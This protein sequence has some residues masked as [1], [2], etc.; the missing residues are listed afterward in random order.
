MA[1]AFY[2]NDG[3]ELRYPFNV[4]SIEQQSLSDAENIELAGLIEKCNEVL[5]ESN[6][7]LASPEV[8]DPTS[9][10]NAVWQRIWIN[11][12]KEPEK[13]LYNVV[14]LFVF[15]F[16]SDVGVLK[17][18][19]NFEAVYK[20]LKNEKPSDA[21][22]HYPKLCRAKIMSLFPEG[23]DGTTIINGTIFVNEEGEPNLAQARLFGEIIVHFKNYE[24]RHGS[25]RYIKRDFK[26]RLY[27][28]FLRQSA[29]VRALGQYFTPR[30]V[31]KAIVMMSGAENLRSGSRVCDPFCGVGGFLLELIEEYDHI[32]QEFV[33]K[34]GALSP[35]ITLVGYDKGSDE[36]EDERTIILA[37][38]NMLIYFSD[39]L[40]KHHSKKDLE[41]FATGALNA[42]FRLLR[43]NL[44]T[45]EKIDDL[46]Y[47][48]IMTNPPYVT[49]G[50]SSIRRALI[51]EGHEERYPV[52][53]HGTEALAMQWVIRNL[54]TRG[55]AFVIVPDGLVN[56]PNLLKH[57]KD[58]CVVRGIVSLPSRTFYAT[59][60]RTY[61]LVLRKK[62]DKSVR[63]TEPTFAYVISEI[64]ET[65]DA[66]RMDLE[67]NDL[68][69]MV[70]MFK[71]F[72]AVPNAFR[73]QS[74]R[75][76]VFDFESFDH[77]PNWMI[78]RE[79]TKDERIGLKL[80]ESE[81]TLSQTNYASRLQG[82]TS[83]LG[84]FDKK[85]ILLNPIEES[86]TLNLG[87]TSLFEFVKLK[88][89]WKKSQYLE[90]DTGNAAD[91]PVYSAA[92]QPVAHVQQV[93]DK[94]ID[95]SPSTRLL[96]FGSNG[97]G[98]AGRNFVTHDCPF[99]VSNDRT[100]L[101]MLCC[102]ILPEF[103]RY[104]LQPMK[105][106]WGFGFTF[107]AT[108]NNLKEVA[109]DVPVAMDGSFD[110]ARQRSV[111]NEF[112]RLSA[113]RQEIEDSWQDLVSARVVFD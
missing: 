37:K 62:P 42:V 15:K 98:S 83:L 94:L 39:L 68:L 72:A 46:P 53:G 19:Y 40:A 45:F 86:R 11:T 7:R 81:K 71:Q 87:D 14:E 92:A 104:A 73:P 107:K 38:A 59:P 4:L 47:D 24:R 51:A 50:S 111:G 106:D 101:K 93:N 89:G 108:P 88:T 90:L 102:D 13:C 8:L 56:Q 110:V 99:Y 6:N 52:S 23:A 58:E 32:R 21:L 105:A 109:F 75:C 78:D 28:S 97:D 2:P 70:A 103:V 31:V 22:M 34:N 55:D 66:R 54:K 63:Q 26:T 74:P 1:N 100:V 67:Q 77:F 43:S 49:S 85:S 112:D 17:G 60:K 113:L 61:I 95:C 91:I 64:G 82:L 76:K 20:V 25:F 12:G 96:S 5:T 48:L 69:E 35:R 27:E 65:R 3:N 30:N 33:P 41:A 10:A 80:D 29:G 16:L 84:N 18:S 57:I 9:L 44:G 79:W 36:K